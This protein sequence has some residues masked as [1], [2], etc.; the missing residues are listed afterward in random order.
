MFLHRSTT[1]IEIGE[2]D[3]FLKDINDILHELPPPH[4]T[5]LSDISLKLRFRLHHLRCD[6]NLRRNSLKPE[7]LLALADWSRDVIRFRRQLLRLHSSYSYRLIGLVERYAHYGPGPETDR[8]YW[9]KLDVIT[10]P[11]LFDHN[12]YQFLRSRFSEGNFKVIIR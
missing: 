12:Q 11:N 10:F 7:H 8:R 4:P 2:G 3:N 6:P 9:N 1:L 5:E